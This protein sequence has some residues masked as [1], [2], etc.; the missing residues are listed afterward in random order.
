VSSVN[1]PTSG[2]AILT[3]VPDEMRA[4]WIAGA[5]E[6]RGIPTMVDEDL[7][8]DE[9]TMSQRLLGAPRVR[10]L[11]PE[12]RLDEAQAVFLAL[13][14]PIPLVEVADEDEFDEE[15]PAQLSN[16]EV[17]I[18]ILAGIAAICGLYFVVAS[19]AS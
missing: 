8:V 5:L 11:V 13:S 12:D 19:C 18:A 15:A 3:E 4:H 1:L 9:F 7:L 17:S 16:T 10:V 2:Y 6:A 14:Q